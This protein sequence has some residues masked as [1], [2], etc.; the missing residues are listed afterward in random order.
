MWLLW[1]TQQRPQSRLKIR[2]EDPCGCGDQPAV[3]CDRCRRSSD[4]DVKERLEQA[5]E[6]GA[7]LNAMS[8]IRDLAQTFGVP[9]SDFVTW[10]NSKATRGPELRPTN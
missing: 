10:L 6:E 1:R 3:V 2:R 9:A 5:Q 4:K 8:Q 7:R